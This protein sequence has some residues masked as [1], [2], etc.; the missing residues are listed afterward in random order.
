[1]TSNNDIERRIS[2]GVI[3]AGLAGS[4][5]SA[6]LSKLDHIDVFC[7]E[8]RGDPR[9]QNDELDEIQSAFGSSISSKKRSVNL[10][11]SHRGIVALSEL[12][13]IDDI[14]KY[15]VPM[16]GRVIHTKNGKIL[17]Q[18]YGKPSEALYSISRQLINH[19]LLDKLE[20]L[21]SVAIR[22]NHTLIDVNE[23][24]S[25]Q[26]ISD[27]GNRVSYNFDLVIGADGAYSAT[28]EFM[29]KK[30]RI[31]FSRTYIE[32]GY[33]ELNIP[34]KI[35]SNGKEYALQ[36]Y[37]GLHIWPRGS[38]MMI[39]LPNPDKSFTANIFAPY[40]GNDGFD[41]VDNNDNDSIVNYFKT[42]FPEI[43]P[44]IPNLVNEYRANPIG[45]LVSIKVN[46]WNLGKIVLLGD[47]AHAIVPFFGQG[48][49]AAFEDGHILYTMLKQSLLQR[50]ASLDMQ[51]QHVLK[52]FSSYRRPATDC[53]GDLCIEHYH[54]MASNTSSQLYLLQKQVYAGISN[55]LGSHFIPLYTLIS[56]T[57]IP[58]HK[59]VAR[60]KLQ[61]RI[62]SKIIL[63]STAAL[64]S[65]V[66]LSYYKYYF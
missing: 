45:S 41:S 44:L 8:K 5:I 47:A 18:P 36:D 37:N 56:F 33:K 19:K 27:D 31:N 43:I 46:P 66:G 42:N 63:S 23:D 26:F 49:N 32:H 39:A 6:L 34:P 15:A 16:P 20:S 59:A 1:M 21:S 10:A 40:S 58:Y 52:E 3:G 64:F 11:L 54:D 24:G 38:F 12:S 51:I 48:M 17:K 53:L 7:F 25:A 29:L 57:S 60:A 30:S 50:D 65:L 9:S 2:V 13:L 4:M 62:I 35:T 22:F 14:M 55:I 61:D 28:R